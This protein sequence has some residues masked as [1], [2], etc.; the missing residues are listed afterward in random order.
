[1]EMINGF[2][3]KIINYLH[4]KFK[5]SK[6]D[7]LLIALKPYNP[8]LVFYF[9]IILILFTSQGTEIAKITSWMYVDRYVVNHIWIYFLYIFLHV[10]ALFFISIHVYIFCKYIENYWCESIIDYENYNFIKIVKYQK[11]IRTILIFLLPC[12][13]ILM[14]FYPS[15]IVFINIFLLGGIILFW[16]LFN[17]NVSD[18]LNKLQ[19]EYSDK[20]EEISSDISLLK[21][22]KAQTDRGEQSIQSLENK[23]YA[24]ESEK[25]TMKIRLFHKLESQFFNQ[26]DVRNFAKVPFGVFAIAIAIFV[27]NPNSLFIDTV[28]GPL[29]SMFLGL[30]FVFSIFMV[31]Y[32]LNKKTQIPFIS[33]AFV[34]ILFSTRF[35]NNHILRTVEGTSIECKRQNLDEYIDNWIDK[36][37]SR[38]VINDS[39]DNYVYLVSSEGGGIR[40]AYW[41]ANILEK[42]DTEFNLMDKTISMSGVSGGSIGLVT[43]CAYKKNPKGNLDKVFDEDLIT[44]TITG[45][46]FPEVV[47]KFIPCPINEWDRS[48]RL[49]DSWSN[50]ITSNISDVSIDGGLLEFWGSQEGYQLPAIFFNTTKVED[51]RKAIFSNIE[52]GGK[53]FSSHDVLDSINLDVPVKSAAVASARFPYITPPAKIVDKKGEYWGNLVDGGYFDNSGLH[54]TFQIVKAIEDNPKAKEYNIIPVIIY[55]KNSRENKSKASSVLIETLSPFKTFLNSWDARVDY[56]IPDLKVL[57]KCYKFELLVF[58]LNRE[59][60]GEQIDFPLAWSFSQKTKNQMKE[61]IDS[62]GQE[63]ENGSTVED[64]NVFNLK[65]IRNYE[66]A[67]LH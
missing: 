40:A 66:K 27:L 22:K 39:T 53:H 48:R 31:W 35:N 45:L 20:Q 24:K 67:N 18:D 47:Q 36:K 4:D 23:I 49:E 55:L 42:L 11:R 9:L 26:K 44:P 21:K 58:E 56:F 6:I 60:D 32:L 2:I 37:Y 15:K 13:Y 43:Y 33:I 65:K 14:C 34:W 54:T 46:L 61:V 28:L 1:M 50:A 19:K 62:F 16:Y 7:Y 63:K 41:T 38:G 59:V 17:L 29:L 5:K 12:I 51:G 10:F 3:N 52:L 64:S 30:L 25:F 8:I 57:S